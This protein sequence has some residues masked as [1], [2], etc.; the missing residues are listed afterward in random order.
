MPVKHSHGAWL[1]VIIQQIWICF[2]WTIKSMFL[3]LCYFKPMIS[4]H[5]LPFCFFPWFLISCSSIKCYNSQGSM[6][7]CLTPH[8]LFGDIFSFSHHVNNHQF[9]V[10]YQLLICNSIQGFTQEL[11]NHSILDMH[12]LS[13]QSYLKYIM[14]TLFLLGFFNLLKTLLSNMLPDINLGVNLDFSLFLIIP[15]PINHHIL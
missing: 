11:Q 13:S 12:T 15:S 14:F 10:G 7:E 5:I 4:Y 6:L 3:P 2:C 8:I 9:T 1:T